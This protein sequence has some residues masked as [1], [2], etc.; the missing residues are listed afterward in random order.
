M[1]IISHREA[2][3]KFQSAEMRMYTVNEKKLNELLCEGTSLLD[4]L[5]HTR[6]VSREDLN[7]FGSVLLDVQTEVYHQAKT[8][9]NGLFV[10]RL[11]A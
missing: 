9:D 5:S 3:L 4:K 8:Q 6:G 2:V 10:E 7:H 11:Q 1:G